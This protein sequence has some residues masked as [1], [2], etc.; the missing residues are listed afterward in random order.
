MKV[1]EKLDHIRARIAVLHEEA[2]ELQLP[3]GVV[4]G[5]HWLCKDAESVLAHL[6]E[7][8]AIKKEDQQ[9]QPGDQP[10]LF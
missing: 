5:L 4:V 8:E 7:M 9:E 3:Q 6:R 1:S 10:K 2:E